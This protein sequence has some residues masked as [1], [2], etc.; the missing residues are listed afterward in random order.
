MNCGSE[1]GSLAG[2]SVGKTWLGS[3]AA[4]QID[5]CSATSR[6]CKKGKKKRLVMMRVGFEPTRFPTAEQ[7]VMVSVY[8]NTAPSTL[9]VSYR[10][11]ATKR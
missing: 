11:V 3:H 7:F 5:C 6:A 10:M 8:L 2:Q 4:A 9:E 1:R